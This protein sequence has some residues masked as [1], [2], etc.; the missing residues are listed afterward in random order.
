MYHHRETKCEQKIKENF[1]FVFLCKKKETYICR[2]CR[3]FFFDE[4]FNTASNIFGSH[5]MKIQNVEIPPL[6]L[7]DGGFPLCNWLLKPFNFT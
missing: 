7:G 6:L 5:E 4:L 3:R 1:N 2:R